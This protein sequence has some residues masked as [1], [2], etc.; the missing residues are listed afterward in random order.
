MGR[1]GNRKTLQQ[2]GNLKSGGSLLVTVACACFSG[3][4]LGGEN[5]QQRVGA[6]TGRRG[7][8]NKKSGH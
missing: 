6:P 5:G 8:K 2:L 3:K 4:H 7:T 1:V